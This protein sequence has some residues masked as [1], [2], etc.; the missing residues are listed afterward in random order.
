MPASGETSLPAVSLINLFASS[1]QIRQFSMPRIFI[2]KHTYSL[3]TTAK[4]VSSSSVCNHR[5]STEERRCLLRVKHR[6]VATA[7][8]FQKRKHIVFRFSTLHMSYFSLE[9]G[10]LFRPEAAQNMC[11]HGDGTPVPAVLHRQRR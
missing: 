3:M 10:H 5:H 8:L 6:L 9:Q 2:F 7:L 11:P 4:E 1:S